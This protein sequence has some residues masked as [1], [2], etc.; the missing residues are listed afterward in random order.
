MT[1]FEEQVRMT[2]ISA[3]LQHLRMSFFSK[4]S[5]VVLCNANLFSSWNTVSLKQ[6]FF[7]TLGGRGRASTKNLRRSNLRP[8]E[9]AHLGTG[10]IH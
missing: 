2:A 4:R 10:K 5:V 6:I 3:F 8:G 7:F 9:N 1:K